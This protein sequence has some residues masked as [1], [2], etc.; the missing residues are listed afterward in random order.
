MRTLV[1]A[2]LLVSVMT[3]TN[4]QTNLT[5]GSI[6]KDSVWTLA[7]S[8]YV[9][10]GN[11]TLNAGYTLTVD[12][13][14]VVQ[15]Q[16]GRYLY[17]AG[18]LIARQAVFTSSK[19]TAGGTP[20]S[21]DWGAIYFNNTGATGRLDTCDV[22]FG[23]GGTSGMILSSVTMT[24]ASFTQC[25]ILNSNSRGIYLSASDSVTVTNCTVS[26]SGSA[27]ISVTAPTMTITGGSVT[28]SSGNGVYLN[29]G[30]TTTV[31]DLSISG[32]TSGV[33]LWIGSTTSSI[34]NCTISS[35]SNQGLMI[36]HGTSANIVNTQVTASGAEGIMLGY[37]STLSAFLDS[38]T[39]S[40]SGSNA[41]RVRGVDSIHATTISDYVNSGIYVYS[42]SAAVVAC[43]ITDP[44]KVTSNAGNEF[45]IGIYV[46]ANTSVNLMNSS[47][48]YTQWPIWYQ[49]Q[50]AFVFNGTNTYANNTHM[51]VNLNFYGTNADFVLDTV[52]L[53]YVFPYDFTV[54][55]GNTMTVATT[56]VL[57]FNGG[58][59]TI[60]GALKAIA[61]V[62]EKIYFTSYRDD[63][64]P[65][66]NSDTNADG[67]GTVPQWGNWYGVVFN[68][69]SVDSACV[70]RRCAVYFAGG[71]NTGGITMYDASPTV[72]SCDLANNYFGAMMQYVSD[73]VF[74]NNSIGSSQ[75]VPIAMAF[76]ANPVFENNVFTNSDNTYDALG[77]LGGTLTADAVLPIRAVL[78][79]NTK[80]AL[81]ALGIDTI[82]N[83]T[84]LMLD[85]VTVPVGM[86]LTINKGV[87]IK[88]YQ[89]W[90]R[91]VVKGKFMADASPDSMI[92]I[93]SASDDN[94]GHPNDTNK[95]G[96]AT[97]PSR[98]DWSGIIFE[99]GSDSSS[100]V[101]NCSLHYGALYYYY[102]YYNGIYVNGGEITTINNANPTI[103]NCV[104]DQGAYG[105]YAYG[106]SKP[107]ISNTKIVN[108]Q[109][110]PIAM[111][112]NAD[113]FFSADTFINP[114]LTALGIVGENLGASGTIR[115]RTV[116]GFTNIT[117]VL[118]AD[119]N[120]N[121]GTTVTV[122][123]G[124]VIKSGGP[125]F[126]VSGGLHAKGT[127]AGGNIV[128]TS[129]RD[130]NFGNPFDTNRDGNSSQPNAGDWSTIR[131]LGTSIDSICVLD[132]CQINYAGSSSWGGVTYTDAG[133]TISNSTIFK[134]AN[135]GIRCE[136]S[137]TPDVVNVT[138]NGCT[139]SPIAMS[140]QSNPT[141]T[142][143][144]FAANGSQGIRILDNTLSS[145]ATLIQRSLAGITNIAY[146]MD[147]LTINSG[148]ILTISPGVVI[149]FT[150]YYSAIT[151]NGGL[152]ADGTAGQKIIFTSFSDDSNGGDTNND[153]NGS[154]PGKGNWGTINFGA[155]S[156]D[157]INSLKNCEFRYGGGN[158]YNYDYGIV[159]VY[160]TKIVMD[161]CVVSQSYNS[162]I[163]VFGSGNPTIS[164]TEIDNVS[165]T[166]V[167][168]SMFSDPTF[169]NM[170]AL[171]VGYMAMGIRPETYSITQTIPIRSFAGY[172]NIT[173]LLY[174][175]ITV[176]SGTTITVPA[177][178]VFKDGNWVVNGALA[179]NGTPGENVVFTDSKDDSFG[180][181]GDT[182]QDGSSSTPSI[183]G[184][185][186]V[187]F[188]D[189]S[190]D[191]ASFLKYTT[192]RY[193]DGGVWLGQA[194]PK[195]LDCTFD[196]DNWGVYLTGVS[197]P[198]VDSCTFNNLTYAP[199]RISLVSYP[200]SASGDV[201]SGSTFKAIGVLNN[202][203]LVQDVTLTRRNF[204][205]ITNIPYLFGNYTV[206]NNSILTI[207]PGLVLKFFPTTSLTI[208]KGLIAVGNTQP[209]SVIVFTDLRD[210]FYG[211]DTNSD[212]TL[213]SPTAYTGAPFYWYGGWYGI[214]FTSETLAP[215]CILKN[216][217]IRYAG[218]NNS[219][220]AVTLNT[221]SPTITY[222]NFNN[223]Y[224]AIVANGS[225]N[226]VINYCDIAQNNTN[227]WGVNNVGG[228]FTID[229]T[230]NWWGSN[231]GPTVATNPGGTGQKVSTLVN[232][233]PFLNTGAQNPLAG[234]VSLNGQVQ[235]YDASLIL[236]WKVDSAVNHLDAR[237]LQA[238]D[239]TGDGTVGSLDASFILQYVVGLVQTFPVDSA[240]TAAPS[241]QALFKST[242]LA[243]ASIDGG[244]V[245]RGQAV[246][247]DLAVSGLK[248]LRGAD[249]VLS[250]D[251]DQLTPTSVKA[252]RAIGNA[253]VESSMKDGV[254]RISLASAS[255][256]DADGAILAITFQAGDDIRGNVDSRITFDQFT[257]NE[258]NMK[259]LASDGVLKIKGKPT[260]FGLSQNYP[261][262]FNPSTTIRYQ[263]PD[264]GQHV[265]IVVYNI[266]GQLVRTLV[267]ADQRAGEYNVVWNGRNDFGQQVSTGVYFFRMMANNFV[268]VKKM[269]LVK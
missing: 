182:N 227:G 220:A 156:A 19:D 128:F 138:L 195:I 235:A 256:L 257:V 263:V 174:G 180:N 212:S 172:S 232:Y 99:S 165:L 155:S 108:A 201:I 219:G 5:G 160:N 168:I 15:F 66:P 176:N 36:D 173:Y 226:P 239:V 54:N 7:G 132:S 207:K 150:N 206:A 203:T 196:K 80:S 255:A 10:S 205:G 79:N 167:T 130:D 63:N 259:S 1:A 262:P 197:N 170:T 243:Q 78:R 23:G 140:L 209:D 222:S 31:S 253:V 126:Y 181:P 125:G 265:K 13:G 117:Y 113:P 210:D 56:N 91:F 87:V 46:E 44:T 104:I 134:S 90:D 229:A 70:M 258:K 103:S 61:S 214:N 251:K 65:T 166:P 247:V 238:A 189:V 92:V 45:P 268:S 269:L 51:G 237:Q 164:N 211:G 162:G 30:T 217:V 144:T 73:P 18:A 175:T 93:T 191:S 242:S 32:S 35:S 215:D 178:V 123:P 119:L 11:V 154:P 267:D 157:T 250:Y 241:M 169:S 86:T 244:S 72:D 190:I 135:F 230:N 177:G 110:T 43:T 77:L 186:R 21:G 84:Y 231:T 246:T 68:N 146:I 97:Q 254:I 107:T 199:L 216:V 249:I 8:P 49:G 187:S 131:F 55:T 147:N 101:N 111:S 183:Q 57:K 105:V 233:Q 248:G 38:C 52:S 83:V 6:S 3:L 127:M 95:N 37:N 42:G 218:L 149:K 75:L 41:I 143:I 116:S 88:G 53:P 266:A 28:S 163:G 261:N 185:Q 50:C 82:S 64:L 74:T 106:S 89:Y 102:Y 184:F 245:D 148:A 4:A 76:T 94:F 27:G 252:T 240:G 69:S 2:L 193:T 200:A 133:G 85:Q 67:S 221:A 202:E 112:V 48:T 26:N 58:H 25:N 213:T 234:D 192:F 118:L 224:S 158:V 153:A 121:S 109:Y 161:S 141:F 33:G 9:V 228:A 12:S 114:G 260:S 225:S 120:I 139:G 198:G 145:N 71:G 98:G 24:S 96:N 40:G 264:D 59:L 22:K 115:Q 47:I 81:G 16:S 171:N 152:V 14:V 34:S 136:N 60:N 39:V 124:V 188:N 100:V 17:V 159:R 20:Q 223:N 129:L 236:K 179:T 29:G 194:S 204:A 122:D 62:G 208:K 142:N 151:V 137:S